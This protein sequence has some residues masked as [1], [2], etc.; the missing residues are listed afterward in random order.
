VEYEITVRYRDDIAAMLPTSEVEIGGKRLKVLAI[1]DPRGASKELR[2]MAE[3][4][5]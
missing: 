2:I 4:I 3:E 5:V 1:M